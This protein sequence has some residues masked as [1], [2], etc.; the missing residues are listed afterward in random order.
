MRELITKNGS[1]TRA[2]DYIG[3]AAALD[4]SLL[5][6]YVPP[7]GAGSFEV[8]LRAM[9][10]SARAR[11]FDPTD[12]SWRPIADALPNA[13]PHAFRLPGRNAAKERDWVLV[14]DAAPPGVRIPGPGH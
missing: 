11:W 14:L 2:P 12:G 10:G 4:G 6:A 9:R 3:A 8:D 5:V 1:C 13:A 7:D